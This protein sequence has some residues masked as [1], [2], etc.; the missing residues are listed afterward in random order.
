MADISPSGTYLYDYWTPGTP[1]G[2]YTVSARQKVTNTSGTIAWDFSPPTR[3]I[4]VGRPRLALTGGD[5]LSTYPQ[6]GAVSAFGETLPYVSLSEPTLPWERELTGLATAP[7]LALFL[8]TEDELTAEA[9][10]TGETKNLLTGNQGTGITLPKFTE[11]ASDLPCRVIDVPAELFT[12]IAP[13]PAELKYLAHARE[14]DWPETIALDPETR[15]AC[16]IVLSNRFPRTPGTYTAHLVSLVGHEQTLSTPPKQGAVRIISLWT[17]SF[18]SHP[19]ERHTFTSL[20]ERL[21]P[22]TLRVPEPPGA[23]THVKNRLASGYVPVAYTT[24]TGEQT[25]AWYRGPLAP[26]AP[27]SLAEH[28][29][30]T[31]AHEALVYLEDVGMFDISYATAWTLGYTLILSQPHLATTMLDMRRHS[32]SRMLRLAMNTHPG[33]AGSPLHMGTIQ[34]PKAA[35]EQPDTGGWDNEQALD[36]LRPG[37]VF[38]RFDTLM[39]QGLGQRIAQGLTAAPPRSTTPPPTA[40]GSHPAGAST[41]LAPHLHQL[42]QREDLTQILHTALKEELRSLRPRH[43]G[44]E[45]SSSAG[46][47]DETPQPAEYL[48]DVLDML[49]LVPTPHLLP[50]AEEALPPDSIQIFDIDTRWLSAFADGMLSIG[51]HTSLDEMISRGLR[52]VLFSTPSNQPQAA[53]GVLLRSPLVTD[54]PDLPLTA[55]GAEIIKRLALGT[56]TTLVFFDKRP[57]AIELREPH[58]TLRF[59]LDES[60]KITLRGTGGQPA[61]DSLAVMAAPGTP[62][63]LLRSTEVTTRP[64][65][66]LSFPADTDKSPAAEKF[67]KYASGSSQLAFQM[68][69]PPCALNI[70]IS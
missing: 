36:S 58:H 23:G 41:S 6:P 40:A 45:H 25:T 67:R 55:P 11:T 5:I 15:Q 22:G 18:A 44:H 51:S 21:T 14:P 59:G 38:R 26:H 30:L 29:L 17:W 60:G 13:R 66:V 32:T 2:S 49:A 20:A 70:T 19:Q 9:T 34:P 28:S 48:W 10:R 33:F 24:F 42:L 52:R 50:W 8:F 62:E 53:C 63:P 61:N 37:A 31:S 1:A 12:R 56:D 16:S 39:A 54:W 57:R 65:D 35:A 43:P 7:W 47:L 68:I 69:Q 4:E 64:R 3:T 27:T 46:I